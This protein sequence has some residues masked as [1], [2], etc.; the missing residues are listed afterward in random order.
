MADLRILLGAMSGTSADGVDVAVVRVTGRGLGLRA[1]LIHHH[2]RPYDPMTRGA[3]FELREAGRVSLENLNRV[4]REITLT[5]AAACN[6]ALFASRT[7]VHHVSAVAAHGQTLYHHPPLTMQWLDPSLLAAE[8]GCAVVSDFRRADCAAGGQGAP[9]VPFADY[10]LFRDAEHSRVLVNIG[11]IANLTCLR[12]GGTPDEVIAFDTGPGNCIADAIMRER[13]GEAFDAGGALALGGKVDERLARAMLRQDYFAGEPPKTTDVPTMLEGYRAARAEVFGDGQPTVADELA[14]ACRIT[15][16]SIIQAAYL[17]DFVPKY[18]AEVI[19]SGG[20][21]KNA[22]MMAA[23]GE[24]LRRF[25]E[26]GRPDRGNEPALRTIDELGYPS[27]S[28][29]AVAFALL[30][31]ATLEDFP[32]NLPSATGARRAVVLGSITPKPY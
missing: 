29:E 8:V 24:E 31:A 17:M 10:L 4:G 2:H 3:L 20:G 25:A 12:S 18:P 1:Q 13:T 23:M 22:A 14:T 16:R 6:E 27:Q 30:G 9:L 32:S 28:K 7:P 26:N 11:G 19:V 15:A 21:G 5:Y